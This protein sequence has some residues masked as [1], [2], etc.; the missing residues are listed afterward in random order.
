MLTSPPSPLA[1]TL[2]FASFDQY[3]RKV[4]VPDGNV[5]TEVVL[6]LRIKNEVESAQP[7]SYDPY[8]CK[9]LLDYMNECLD[10]AGPK[11]LGSSI[12]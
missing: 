9:V 10:I 6:A 4:F 3:G 5:M 8:T 11:T 12:W 1:C 2:D 7:P